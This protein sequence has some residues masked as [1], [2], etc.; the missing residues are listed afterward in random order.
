MN[1]TRSLFAL[2]LGALIAIPAFPGTHDHLGIQMWSLRANTMTKGFVA[3]LD[4]V[5]AWGI[6][7]VEGGLVTAG[8]TPA[9][10][11]AAVD[12][13]GLK[14]PSAHVQYGALVND[15]DAM[16]DAAKTLGVS[17]VICPW[18]PHEGAFDRAV[19]EKAIGDFSRA[20]AAFRAAGIKFGY[21]PHGYEFGPGATE[22]E[23][24]LDGL[25][26]GTNPD[27]VCFQMD[28]FWIVHGGGD[29]VALLNKYAG[30]WMGLHV[31][32]LRK[33]APMG[34]NI[35]RAPDTDNVAVGTGAVDWV[36]VLSTAEKVG[37][38]HFFIEDETPAPLENIPLT[39]AYLRSL[40]Y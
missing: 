40:K 30:R 13:R 14:M 36:A 24:L 20:G 17:Y 6:P 7:E 32:D 25:I 22:G 21:H 2:C 8:M 26:Q 5:Q 37:A 18:I 28:V 34:L 3:S 27:D 1:V 16:V 35:G 38:K 19:V 4:L 15:L 31:K 33:G 23:T 9:E 39:L 11:K 12:E 10:V 29:P